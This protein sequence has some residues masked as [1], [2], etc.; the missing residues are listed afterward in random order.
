ME[1]VPKSSNFV[2]ASSP[3]RSGSTAVRSTSPRKAARTL[4]RVTNGATLAAVADGR[5]AWARRLRDLIA[6]HTSDLGGAAQLSE[7]RRQLVRRAAT[8]E[9]ALEQFD[10]K[11]AQA[12][13]ASIADLDAYQRAAGNLRRL[14]ESIGLKRVA[15]EVNP[16]E[17]YLADRAAVDPGRGAGEQ[18]ADADARGFK[19]PGEEN[20]E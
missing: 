11:F 16:V 20:L 13:E 9:V 18:P 15:R 2:A 12:E 5:G 8:I 1:Y 6:E 3:G 7:A 19:N 10:A 4:S 17:Q 14:L